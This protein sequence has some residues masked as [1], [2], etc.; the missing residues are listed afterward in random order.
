MDDDRR[1]RWDERH[2]GAEGPGEVAQILTRN[3]GLLPTR[4]KVLDLACGR[5]GNALW[6]AER[7][8]EICACDYSTVAIDYLQG[9]ARERQ[10]AID[11]QLRDVISYPPEAESFDLVVVSHFLDRELCPAIA[12]AL[13]P[14]ALLCY[15]TFGPWVDG[16]AGPSNPAFRLAENELLTLFR[17][18]R[19]RFYL[20]PGALAQDDSRGLA[21]LVAQKPG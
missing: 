16:A 8:L 5:G 18:L 9:L 10:L 21:M 1:A 19:V 20:E 15:Q 7:G 12:A 2:A 4:G 11:A 3:A 13:K 17:G 14:G 6:L